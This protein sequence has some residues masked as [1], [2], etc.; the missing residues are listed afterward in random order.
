MVYRGARDF[1]LKPLE[2]PTWLNNSRDT[3]KRPKIGA[4][5]QKVIA[6]RLIPVGL[7]EGHRAD[8]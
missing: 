4:L 5:S 3:S 6:L 1:L 7:E 8:Y 2:N